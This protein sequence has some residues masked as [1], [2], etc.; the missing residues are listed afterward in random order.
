MACASQARR[1]DP[2]KF[3]SGARIRPATWSM[4]SLQPQTQPPRQPVLLRVAEESTDQAKVKRRTV[5]RSARIWTRCWSR[6]LLLRSSQPT[7]STKPSTSSST[8]QEGQDHSSSGD[9]RHCPRLARPDDFSLYTT[10]EPSPTPSI[11][12]V[13][14]SSYVVFIRRHVIILPS[15]SLTTISC[16]F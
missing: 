3:S 13:T 14:I 10:T 9:H 15:A 6:L 5:A 11:P 7:S 12:T 4:T 2:L 8:R 16:R 1:L